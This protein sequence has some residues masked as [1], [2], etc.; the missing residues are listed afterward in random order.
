MKQFLA[1]MILLCTY[2]GNAQPPKSPVIF[3]LQGHS[4][5]LECLALSANGVYIASGSWDGMVNIFKTDS[6]YTPET[7]LVD[8]FSAVNCISITPNNKVIATAGND[9]KV[10]T[11]KIDSFGIILKD[12]SASIHRMSIN[13]LYIDP[14][15]KTVY[16]GS[17][18]GTMSIYDLIKGKDKRI[19]NTNPIT[20]IAVTNDRRSIFCSDNTNSIKKYDVIGTLSTTLEGHTD[21]VNCIIISK[22]NK[23][24][25]SASSDKTIKVW[26]LQKNKVEKTLTGH[27][28][29]V[30]TI[31]LS[32]D[33][34]YLVSGSNDG[35]LKLWEFET[36]KELQSFDDIGSN[37]RSVAI[38]ADNSKIYAAMH[39]TLDSFE[40]AGILV[41]KTGITPVKKEISNIPGKTPAPKGKTTPTKPGITTPGSTTTP[42]T[43][44]EIIKK[45]PEIEISEE[46]KKTTDTKKDADR[47]D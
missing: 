15:G 33:G 44:K 12:K 43:T 25:I 14:S 8:H 30:L 38:S 45:T 46:K 41:L 1:I 2:L 28:W 47:K 22:D 23:Y 32:K 19:T 24:L 20:S 3:K 36:G 37:V 6:N 13:A 26:N 27:D 29:K 34:K 17:N 39:Y 10:F 9:G 42:G 18:D 5:D 40:T 7:S 4:D 35:S 16:T 21:Q 11:Y 31:A